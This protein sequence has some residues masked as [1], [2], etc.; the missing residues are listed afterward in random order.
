M[1]YL[2]DEASVTEGGQLDI[3]FDLIFAS[4][5]DRTVNKKVAQKLHPI[6]SQIREYDA[7]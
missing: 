2:S 4:K 7:E 1:L 6:T 3:C 5:K